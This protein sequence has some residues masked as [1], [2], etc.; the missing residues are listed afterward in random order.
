MKEQPAGHFAR[1]TKPGDA[2][3]IPSAPSA[4]PGIRGPPAPP[5]TSPPVPLVS[6]RSWFSCSDRPPPSDGGG[7]LLKS[8]SSGGAPVTNACAFLRK[9]RPAAPRA[10]EKRLTG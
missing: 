3:I 6:P 5:P 1:T 8:P 4:P 9:K 10:S 2:V 7:E